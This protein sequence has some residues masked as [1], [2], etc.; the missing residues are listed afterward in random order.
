MVTQD[1][2]P[3]NQ[4]KEE[5]SSYFGLFKGIGSIFGTNEEDQD[6]PTPQ[7]TY[8]NIDKTQ[9]QS[10][11]EKPASPK[12]P[13]IQTQEQNQTPT[14]KIPPAPQETNDPQTT[15]PTSQPQ[16]D[17]SPPTQT[18]HIESKKTESAPKPPPP[19]P[20]TV[21]PKPEVRISI[22]FKLFGTKISLNYK[23]IRSG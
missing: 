6:D 16:L 8:Q 18:S 10:Q 7:P 11:S 15:P 21:K 20:K 2:R 17:P 4:Q 1:N 3:I 22:P 19:P 12:Q 9:P 14:P 23:Y 13:I 5:N